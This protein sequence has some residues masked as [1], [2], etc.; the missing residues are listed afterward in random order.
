MTGA[1][2]RI[3]LPSCQA[4]RVQEIAAR[5]SAL[6]RWFRDHARSL[7]WRAPIGQRPDPW[8]V[9]VSEILLQQTTVATVR[10]RF[11]DFLARFP[12]PATLARAAREE[13]L[14]AWQG[15][16]YY[17]RAHLLHACARELA[18]RYGGRIPE[19]PE[20]LRRL[21]GIGPYTAAAVAAIA[22]DR[23]VVP[24]DANVER[25]LARLFA[26]DTPLPRGR[27][28]LRA[29]AAALAAGPEPG[30]FAQALMELGALICR[31][32]RPACPRCPLSERCAA[33][34]AGRQQELPRRMPPRPRAR[35]LRVCYV[36]CREDG[37]LLL[38]RRP[39][40]GLLGGMFEPFSVEL[41]GDGEAGTA[42][43][44]FAADWRPLAGRV[45]HRFT[46]IE[47][48]CLVYYARIGEQDA[49]A[50]GDPELAW[51]APAELA[52]LPLSSLAR[53]L[54]RHAGIE[55]PSSSRR[56]ASSR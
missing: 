16:G 3:R 23:A 51:Y 37:A 36:A 44:P 14:H 12:N 40:G 7:P 43:A 24:L 53:K 25:V 4:R 45:R 22:F 50:P 8:R 10:R 35:M 19:A 17:R 41:C 33:R 34:A 42:G 27:R 46:H 15:L 6:L 26:I 49:P 21:P 52:R 30:L 1:N 29:I 38:R 28:A 32:R 55:P 54:L 31:P 13:V 2:M 9:L 5:R 20:E 48:E 11:D 18:S 56:Q 39:E 47:L